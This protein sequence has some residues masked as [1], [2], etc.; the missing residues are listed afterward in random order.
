MSDEERRV[1][2][3]RRDT[4]AYVQREEVG[5]SGPAQAIRESNAT[6]WWLAALAAIVALFALIWLFNANRQQVADIEAA[7]EAGR[8]EVMMD[9]TAAQAHS[10]AFA[11]REPSRSTSADL[12]RAT[13][14]AAADA[15]DAS[16][17]AAL[18][19]QAAAASVSDAAQDAAAEVTVTV[20]D[21]P[22]E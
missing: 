11:A 7:R 14:Q 18:E 21:E 20:P 17:Q 22:V 10:A 9:D 12:A 5:E 15:A 16:R 1:E 3:E 19:A 4:P 6:A 8:A 13:E 2:R